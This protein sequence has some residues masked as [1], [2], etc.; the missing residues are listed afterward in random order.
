M[1]LVVDER[2]WLATQSSTS[3]DELRERFAAGLEDGHV[4][5]VVEEGHAIVG[6]AGVHPTA[7]EGV[8]SLGTWLLASHRGR[9]LGRRLVERALDEA[10]A[11][12][13]RKVEL[14]AFTDNE[15]AIAL[16]RATGFEVEGIRRDH[17]PREDG[18]VRSA[19]VMALFL[20]ERGSG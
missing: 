7:V 15:A 20:E 9:G 1:K 3:E 12:E 5:L 13:I 8:W 17:Y 6:C 4:L 11:R 19:V 14:E 10:S 2:R 18:S 16:Y